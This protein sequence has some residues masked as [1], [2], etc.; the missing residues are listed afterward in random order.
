MHP[1]RGEPCIKARVIRLLFVCASL[2]SCA[3]TAPEWR[4]Y[5]SID[6][7]AGPG[8]VQ[9]F[10]SATTS[11]ECIDFGCPPPGP[12][13]SRVLL[14]QSTDG[15]SAGWHIVLIRTSGTSDSVVVTQLTDGRLYWFKVV[16]LD[17]GG[18]Q[19]AASN[20]IMTMPGS[21]SVPITSVPV[22]MSGRFSWSPSGDSIA[23]ADSPVLSDP[24]LAVLDVGSLAITRLVTYTGGEWIQDAIW[25]ADGS[26]IAYTHTPTQTAGG[27]DYQIWS[28][29]LAGGDVRTQ[30]S[31][32]VDFDPAWGGGGW[33][34]FCRGTYEPPNIPEIW[35]MKEGNV[36]SMQAVTAEPSFYKYSPSVRPSDNSV[37]YAGRPHGARTSG[38]FLVR[39]GG[40]PVPLTSSDQYV[41]SCP[42]WSH[43][44]QH[45]VFVSTRS[46]HSEV[47]TVDVRNRALHQLT[48]GLR[49]V[50]RISA[51]LSP[52]GQRLAVLDGH[53]G[54]NTWRGQL[55]IYAAE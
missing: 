22:E 25:K 41:D 39:A 47:W 55:D 52:N 37:V 2:T 10:W 12:A 32:R 18:R 13:I 21:R 51:S 23:F 16:A 15:P 4:G 3:P 26:A 48:R 27:I 46:G 35:R 28:L 40:S 14:E 43:D 44:G 50:N 31:G 1:T 42:F 49:G 20:P 17:V 36:S 24:G 45:V 5:A 7:Y 54:G 11:P 8:S 29:A 30:S 19:L 9:L 6:S 53:P 33:L 38:L 34:Y